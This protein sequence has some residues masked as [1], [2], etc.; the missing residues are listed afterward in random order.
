M[1]AIKGVGGEGR[2]LVGR[3]SRNNVGK[4]PLFPV[5]V[6]T[7]KDVIFKRLQIEEPG[8]GYVHFDAALDEEYFKQLTSESL[9]TRFR[10]GVKKREFVKLRRRNE[11][12][13]CLVYAIAALHILGVSPTKA[14]KARAVEQAPRPKINRPR[15]PSSGWVNSWR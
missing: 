8:P 9:V 4:C 14:T 2:P 6:H 7:A 13:D 1:F 5:G 12:L 15:R 10:R 3:A 11:A